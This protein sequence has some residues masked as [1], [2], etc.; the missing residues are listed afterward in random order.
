MGKRRI[1]IV[2]LTGITIAVAALLTLSTTAASA[3]TARASAPAHVS[4]P[5]AAEAASG[6]VTETFTIADEPYYEACV[7]DAQILLNDIYYF[8]EK[9]GIYNGVTYLLTVDGSYGPDTMNDVK[10]F[11]GFWGDKVDGE[12]GP[13]TWDTLCS[14]DYNL[15]YRGT[16]W[17]DAGCG[18]EPGL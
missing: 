7:A 3:A 8:Q 10:N 16:Y 18:T 6:C 5:S 2:A 11:Q 13:M 4:A 1:G 17:H 15:G 9:T 12:L 14:T